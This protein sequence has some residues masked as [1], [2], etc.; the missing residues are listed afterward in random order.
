MWGHQVGRV[1]IRTLR[2]IPGNASTACGRASELPS[3]WPPARRSKRAIRGRAIRAVAAR[4]E[5]TGYAKA[6]GYDGFGDTVTLTTHGSQTATPIWTRDPATG[7]VTR[8]EHHDGNQLD[9]GQVADQGIRRPARR[10]EPNHRLHLRFPQRPHR[11]QVRHHCWCI[12]RH[13][14]VPLPLRRLELRGRILLVSNWQFETW[15]FLRLG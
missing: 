4:S 1:R 5:G 3:L 9:G 11:A 15:P 14:R 2:H 6:F 7:L 10:P 13:N 8:K 12:E